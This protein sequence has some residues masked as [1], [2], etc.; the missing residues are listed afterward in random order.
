MM[1]TGAVPYIMNPGENAPDRK[2]PPKNELDCGGTG[3]SADQK[4]SQKSDVVPW[5][6][7]IIDRKIAHSAVVPG[8]AFSLIVTHGVPG[9]R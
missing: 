8:T 6:N 4:I 3:S 7:R 2:Y 9:F 1:R 5:L